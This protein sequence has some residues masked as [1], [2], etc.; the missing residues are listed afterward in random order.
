MKKTKKKSYTMDDYKWYLV[1]DGKT[2]KVIS[3]EHITEY[4]TMNN[5]IIEITPSQAASMLLLQQTF[6]AD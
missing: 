2:T 3:S 4:E 1:G 6:K 5:V